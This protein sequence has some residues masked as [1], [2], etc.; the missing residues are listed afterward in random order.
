[1][2][3]L[4][5]PIFP[6]WQV[7]DLLSQ[8]VSV[9]SAKCPGTLVS[10]GE[11]PDSAS[12]PSRTSQPPPPPLPRG[13][14]IWGPSKEDLAAESDDDE[15]TSAPARAEPSAS[16]VDRA[17]LRGSMDFERREAMATL[18]FTIPEGLQA[19][20]QFTWRSRKTGERVINTV[21]PDKKPGDKIRFQVPV[22]L[23]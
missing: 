6:I 5:Y 7:D 19:G 2:C 10:S 15:E 12:Q 18:E 16:D 4:G 13:S 8:P 14:S 17:S 20:E 11:M 23:L 9:Q 3:T 22:A 21:P 1:M